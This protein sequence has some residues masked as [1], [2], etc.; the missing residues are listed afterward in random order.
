[1]RKTMAIGLLAPLV[2]IAADLY[3]RLSRRIAVALV[4]VTALL[5]L[6][7]FQTVLQNRDGA[8]AIIAGT[9]VAVFVAAMLATVLR[10]RGGGGRRRPGV[11]ACR[12]HRGHS[13]G[14]DRCPRSGRCNRIG[15]RRDAD[16]PGCAL[17]NA[18]SRFHGNIAGRPAGGADR[19]WHP[20]T[21][22]A[23]L[24]RAAF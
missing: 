17:A 3:P 19:R 21:R 7:I 11:G 20:A 10:L 1:A 6:W 14:L 8:G 23:P 24:V 12:Q 5:S 9:A 15:M 2:G 18:R 16:R 4:I 13:F 22:A